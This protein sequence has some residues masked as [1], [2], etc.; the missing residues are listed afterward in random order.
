MLLGCF[1]RGLESERENVLT[2]TIH[3]MCK[4]FLFKYV[5]DVE[6]SLLYF[7]FMMQVVTSSCY[8]LLS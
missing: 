8:F 5:D 3:G 4:L 7:P 2:L 1:G 6:V